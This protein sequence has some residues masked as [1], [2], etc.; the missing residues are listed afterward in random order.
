MATIESVGSSTRIEGVR[1]TNA[2]VEALLPRVESRA[3][4][5]RDEQ[6]VA[7]YAALMETIFGNYAHL[8]LTENYIK[9]MHG[10]LLQHSTKDARHRGQYKNFSNQVEAFGPNSESLGI[11]F[12]TASPFDTP[13]QMTEIVTW[14]R[15]NEIGPFFHPLL[16][17]GAFVVQFL[18]IHQMARERGRI[19][20]G[21]I[22]AVSGETRSTVRARL[23]D[24]VLR[25]LLVRHGKGRATW[26]TIGQNAP[27]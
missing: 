21:E 4:A 7:G 5:S 9:Q 6:E 15:E 12:E 22:G 27:G 2:Q 17:I 1:L 13:F 24:L 20:S 3:F 11:I 23:N 10:I 18:A 19:K 25:G 14:T 26:Y 8:T 16:V